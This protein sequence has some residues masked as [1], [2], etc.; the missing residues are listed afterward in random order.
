MSTKYTKEFLEPYVKD[1]NS[2]RDLLRKLNLKES[3]GNHH[4]LKNRIKNLNINIDHF[5]GQ[6]WRKGKIFKK[7]DSDIVQKYFTKDFRYSTGTPVSSG[8]IKFFIFK[9]NFKEE[10]CEQCGIVEWNGKKAPLQL[11][12]V[13]GICTNNELINLQI[14]CANCH[15]QT[16]NFTGKNITKK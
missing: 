12:H 3:G 9:Y 4:N 1:S 5:L 13:D 15:A 7:I 11:H 8:R 6:D 10:K 2:V 14:L 16:D